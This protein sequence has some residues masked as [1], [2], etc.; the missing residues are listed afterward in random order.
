M[1]SKT[2][3]RRQRE[4][5]LCDPARARYVRAALAR[6]ERKAERAAI[7]RA[8]ADPARR[9]ATLGHIAECLALLDEPGV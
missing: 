3:R 8:A 5:P 2:M 7:E 4:R 9:D 6:K 1:T